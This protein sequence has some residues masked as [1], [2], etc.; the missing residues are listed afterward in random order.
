MYVCVYVSIC[1]LSASDFGQVHEIICIHHNSIATM[2]LEYTTACA[3]FWQ[4][5]HF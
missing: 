2:F 1:C 4:E 5:T 3:D